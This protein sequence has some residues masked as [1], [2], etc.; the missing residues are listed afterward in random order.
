VDPPRQL[1]ILQLRIICNCGTTSLLLISRI[2]S[3]AEGA[4]D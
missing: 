2:V 4:L 3:G 1:P